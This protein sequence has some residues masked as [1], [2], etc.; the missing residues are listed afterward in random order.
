MIPSRIL[1]ATDGSASAKVAEAFAA[2]MAVAEHA[3]T[4]V[5]VT[6]LRAYAAARAGIV[7]PP[8]A[9]VEAAER[10]VAEAAEHILAIIGSNPVAIETKVLSALSE[11]EAIIDEAHAADTC[12]HIVMGRGKGRAIRERA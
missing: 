12:S 4:V 3:S 7:E 11:A 5:V 9:K 8:A 2:E 10:L 6:V 1:V